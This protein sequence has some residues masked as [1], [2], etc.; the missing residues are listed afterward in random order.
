MERIPAACKLSAALLSA[1]LVCANA[2]V[3]R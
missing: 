3:R 2:G 1:A